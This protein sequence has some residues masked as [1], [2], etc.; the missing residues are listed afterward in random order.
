M[1]P[2]Y[3]LTVINND[4]SKSAMRSDKK[5]EQQCIAATLV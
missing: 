2:G 3:N 5:L 1:R 4:V